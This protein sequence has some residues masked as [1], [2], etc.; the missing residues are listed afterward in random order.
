MVD[1]RNRTDSRRAA[2]LSADD[3]SPDG[4]SEKLTVLHVPHADSNPY[5][6]NLTDALE[7]AGVSTVLAS[8]YPVETLRTVAAEGTP[9]VLHLHW[10]APYLVGESRL[11]SL[12]KTA[13]F[14]VGLLAVRLLGV[15]VVW[16]AHNLLEHERRWPSFERRCKSLLTRYVFDRVFVHWPR[17]RRRLI[18]EYDLASDRRG[19]LVTIPHGHYVGDYEDQIDRETARARLDLSTDEFVYLFFGQ[20]RPYKQVPRLIDAF[21][22]VANEETRLVVAGNPTDDELRKRI[23]SEVADD[24]RVRTSLRFVRDDEVQRYMN[25]AD[26]AVFPFR[27]VLTSGSVILAMSFGTAVVAPDIGCLPDVVPDEGGIL[28]DPEES[29]GLPDA[30]SAVRSRNVSAMGRRNYEEVTGYA[31]SDVAGRTAAEYTSIVDDS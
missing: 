1:R 30:M 14:A 7:A 20:I 4:N 17:T 9:D 3:E 27:D 16:T 18:D 11:R 6:T 8:G 28:Y 5:Q 23:E 21:R 15:R 10:I 29:D 2:T 26:V 25:A 12:V 31:W 19:D 13:V 24:E 22:R